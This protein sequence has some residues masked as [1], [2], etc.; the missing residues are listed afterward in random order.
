MSTIINSY[1]GAMSTLEIQKVWIGGG[2]QHKNVK[3]GTYIYTVVSGSI[4]ILRVMHQLISDSDLDYIFYSPFTKI[5][6]P[7]P[8]QVVT[9]TIPQ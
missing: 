1:R 6:F 5:T 7:I 3:E 9:K 2:K 8:L 4:K